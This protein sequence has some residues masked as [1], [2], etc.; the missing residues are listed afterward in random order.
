MTGEIYIL[1]RFT[2]F[3]YIWGT[4]MFGYL[5]HYLAFFVILLL[6]LNACSQY[7]TVKG[8]NQI[9]PAP[10]AKK[11]GNTLREPY[12]LGEGDQ[13]EIQVA[14]QDTLKRTITIDSTG[15]IN[16]PFAGDI[17]ACGLTVPQL[18]D[19]VTLRLSKF[20]VEPQVDVN[21]TKAGSQQVIVLGEVSSPGVF[22]MDGRVT[23]WKAIAL[24]SGFTQDANRKNVLLL[25]N[26]KDVIRASL[27]NLD[28][29]NLKKN[30]N[31]ATT[32]RNIY[33][34]RDDILYV[35]PSMIA[36]AERFFRRIQTV[37]GAF[38]TLESAIVFGPEVLDAL[39][40]ESL[41]DGGSN[42]GIVIS[43]Q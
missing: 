1:K 3:S 4:M 9:Q 12:V 28:M 37:L 25:R 41:D 13:V 8:G 14:R 15:H 6:L 40:I 21:V 7:R 32:A 10:D 34:Q 2:E 22:D 29:G 16:M 38:T 23:A 11:I 30:E 19:E 33:L 24:A 20:F 39:G 5:K 26:D 31:G 27:L 42:T 18:R 36:N 17:E 43:P 35:P